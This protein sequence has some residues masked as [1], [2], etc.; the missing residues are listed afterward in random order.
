MKIDG[1]KN[2]ETA[3][4][5][6]FLTNFPNH[7]RRRQ[8]LVGQ[9]FNSW[10]VIAVAPDRYRN[11]SYWKCQCACGQVFEVSGQTLKNGTSKNCSACTAKRRFTI[12]GATKNGKK[13]PEYHIWNSIKNRCLNP[14]M[15]SYKNYGARGIKISEKW[16]KSFDSF[17][18]DMGYK[19]FT[20]ASIERIDNNGDYCKENCKWIKRKYQSQNTRRGFNFNG[21]LICITKLA[22]KIDRCRFFVS[23]KLKEGFSPDEIK[24][25]DGNRYKEYY[26]PLSP[27]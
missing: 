3:C 22:R 8:N 15:V 26:K 24:K 18:H 1:R 2:K 21:E 17:I 13:I 14:N 12:H 23:R 9:K 5:R 4:E 20:D 16:R 11:R 6:S 25:M 10:L 27:E 7:R 19:P